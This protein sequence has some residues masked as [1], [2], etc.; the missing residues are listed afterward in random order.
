M[1]PSTQSSVIPLAPF[2]IDPIFTT[3][4]WGFTDLRPWY[5]RVADGEP[6]GEV[7]LTG[8]DCAIAT[9]PHKG[10]KLGAMFAEEHDALVGEG[11]PSGSPILI[12]VIFAK[13]K[14]SVQVHPDDAMAR[15]Y[16]LPRGKTEC[17]Y[18]LDAEPGAKVAAG[19]KP[20][21]TLD[22][23]RQEIG[24]GTLE[25]SL[26]GIS[27]ARGDMVFVDSGTVHAIWPGSI[28]LETQQYSDT[29]YRMFDY[30][31]PRELHIEK[32]IEATKLVTRAGKIVPRKLADRTVLIDVEYFRVEQ[33]EVGGSR[34]GESLHGNNEM[35]GLAYLFAASGAGRLSGFGFE[36]VDLP[37]RAI[38]AVPAASPKFVLEDVSG[39]GEKLDLIRITP[40]WPK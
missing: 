1:A 13:D 31:R 26:N 19:L 12:K 4:V 15:R 25:S 37:A 33:I 18:V 34:T 23:V 30:G 3:R 22:Q 24:A 16:G 20:G 28:L 9:G 40:N 11:K 10:E 29:T 8:D 27:V 21:T 2:R 36:A 17:W 7:W 5:D 39:P 14:L 35:P 6:I 32:S 38:V